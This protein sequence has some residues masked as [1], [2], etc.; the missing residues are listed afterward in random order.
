MIKIT[1]EVTSPF[2]LVM[3]TPAP[4][5]E[6]ATSYFKSKLATE[7]GPA[8]VRLDLERARTDFVLLD[9]RSSKD[10]AQCRIPGACS[11]PL[12]KISLETTAVLPKD[13]V[14]GVYCWGVSCNASTKAALK[15]S[16]LGFRVKELIGGIEAWRR[17]GSPVER[18]LGHDAPTWG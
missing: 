17:E 16:M 4:K 9:V 1:K 12:R 6:V 14:I 7:T 10:H 11:I 18:T 2:S 3:E 5:P 13:K 8:D 15:L